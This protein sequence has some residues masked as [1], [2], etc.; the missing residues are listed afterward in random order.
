MIAHIFRQR[1]R[2][3]GKIELART[4][5]GRFRLKGDVRITDIPLY[6]TDKQVAERKLAD[7]INEKERERAGLIAPR[8]QRD[9]AQRTLKE[10]L[11]DFV[12]D[13]KTLGRSQKYCYHINARAGRLTDQCGW[14][15]PGDVSVNNF[16]AWRSKQTKR[17]PKTVNEHQNALNALLNWMTRQGRIEANPLR[18]MPKIDVRG[19]QQM[20]RAYTDD[21]LR[22]LLAVA[23]DHRLIYLTAAYT[24]LRLG[25]LG[26]L[27]WGDL[28]LEHERPHI[29]ARASTTKNRRDAVLPLH[30]MLLAE[31]KAAKAKAKPKDT[32]VRVFKHTHTAIISRYMRA[33]LEAAGIPRIDAMGRRIDFHALRYTFATKLASSGVSQR[34]AQELMRHSDP[35]LTANIYTNV[36]CLPTF[37]AVTEL[38]WTDGE[39]LP[40]RKDAPKPS[41]QLA[42]QTVVFSGQKR[43]NIGTVEVLEELPASSLPELVCADLASSVTT[44]NWRRGG[45]SNPR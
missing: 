41:S 8:L 26:Q 33:D 4:Y 21:E 36:T 10:H 9:S 32:S 23:G 5:R 44:E 17:S 7:I 34:L 11:A 37:E 1:R 27:V 24:G 22:R 35:R 16:V 31:L 3:N 45:D 2:I 13:L 39:P 38:A 43:A 40:Q 15:M 42:S 29:R 20:R 6:T 25:E 12:A 28:Q 30:P 19:K 18:E 14:K